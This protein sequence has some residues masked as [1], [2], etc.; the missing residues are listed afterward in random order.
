MGAL[1]KAGQKLQIAGELVRFFG[2]RRWWMLPLVV[3]V[4]LA[5]V[6]LILGEA[7]SLAP[8]IYTMF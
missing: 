6:L 8:F 3:V 2:R 4:L 7:T 5:G 1:R